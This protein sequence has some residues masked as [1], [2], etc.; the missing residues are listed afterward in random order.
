MESQTQEA[1]RYIHNFPNTKITKVAREFE[2]PIS[3][4]RHSLKG[5]PPKAGQPVKNTKFL[6]SEETI[7]CRYIDWFDRINLTVCIEFVTD[8][9][10]SILQ[11][12]F[13]SNNI[14]AVRRKW[15][16]CFLCFHNLLGA[17]LWRKW[18]LFKLQG[19]QAFKSITVWYKG[20]ARRGVL[21]L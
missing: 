4:L 8:A 11:E 2:V 17:L 3:R 12:R 15:T 5:R 16:T 14:L 10:N 6:R 7:L 9:A 21:R 13:K 1:I 18:E 19:I 20:V